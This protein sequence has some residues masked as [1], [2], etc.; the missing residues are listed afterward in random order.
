MQAW[1]WQPREWSLCHKAGGVG[2][3]F[4]VEEG[5]EFQFFA[6]EIAEVVAGNQDYFEFFGVF[7]YGGGVGVFGGGFVDIH[8]DD[9]GGVVAEAGGVEGGGGDVEGAAVVAGFFAEFAE[10]GDLGGFAFVHDTGGEFDDA[11]AGGGAELAEEDE[12]IGG[13]EPGDEHDGAFAAEAVG[14]FPFA[15]LA[16]FGDVADD[17]E[18][19]EFALSKESAGDFAGGSAGEIAFAA[20]L[21]EVAGVIEQ[22]DD[23]L[24]PAVDAED[25]DGGGVEFEGDFAFPG[26]VDAEPPGDGGHAGVGVHD[27]DGDVFDLAGDVVH[28]AEDAF[29]HHSPAFGAGVGLPVF[30][31]FGDGKLEGFGGFAGEVGGLAVVEFAEFGAEEGFGV[32][33]VGEDLG[34]V[35]G[36]GVVGGVYADGSAAEEVFE[37]F[38]GGDGLAE[39]DFG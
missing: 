6:D 28:G 2:E 23:A 31:G 4:A 35:G 5:A 37:V 30:G 7:G 1:A 15:F 18:V 16:V 22:A 11:A 36:A 12:A 32:E 29:G 19:E 21:F 33:H 20:Q 34:G 17:L 24:V 27:D 8:E 13:F 14:G 3:D 26:A 25:A 9:V 38:T 39:A 10:G